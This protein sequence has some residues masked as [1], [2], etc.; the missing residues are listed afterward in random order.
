MDTII[1]FVN[2]TLAFLMW[3]VIGRVLITLL[4]GPSRPNVMVGFFVKF[5]EPLYRLTRRLFPF[6]LVPSE[7][8]GS[9]WARI[10]GCIPFLAV[11]LIM[12]ARILVITLF[13]PEAKQ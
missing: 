6:A 7:K 3:L 9:A 1:R 13:G 5:T 10:E 8:A 2:F 11:L 4:V 12:I